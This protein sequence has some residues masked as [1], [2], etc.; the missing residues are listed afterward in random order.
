MRPPPDLTRRAALALPGL[1]AGGRA[2][3][4]DLALR[5]DPAAPQRG[6]VRALGAVVWLHAYYREGT[7]PDPLPCLAPLAAAGW[8]CW[9]Q[10][11]AATIDP[12][13]PAAAA[14]AAGTAG[15]RARGYRQVV[16]VGESRGGFVALSALAA[17]GLA[18]AAVL[19][20]PAAHGTRPERRDA[21]LSDYRAA[22][23]AMAP[24]ALRRAALVLFR[25]DPYDP[26]PGE[27][28]AAFRAAMDQRGIPALVIDRPAAPVGHGGGWD[29]AFET[30]FGACLRA[31]VT[32]S[33]AAA[34]APG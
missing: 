20:A 15:L 21:A 32:G 11:R 27:R 4:A 17:P 9:R 3:A 10:D 18:D 6:P 28:A 1:L 8:D 34:C 23:A 33:G 22:L 29:P 25:D 12:L 26:A 2:A 14:L 13:G 24:D 30:R 19:V 16:L 5:A 31:F 7:P